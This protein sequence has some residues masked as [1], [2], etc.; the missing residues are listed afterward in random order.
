MAATAAG[1]AA[2]AASDHSLLGGADATLAG[3]HPGHCAVAGEALER[4]RGRPGQPARTATTTDLLA[5]GVGRL[6]T[7]IEGVRGA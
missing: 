2:R 3:G 7:G 1:A 5:T 4:Q 6:S